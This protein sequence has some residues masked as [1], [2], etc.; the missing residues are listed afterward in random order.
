[1]SL[2]HL[3]IIFASIL[4]S[5]IVVFQVLLAFGLPLGNLAWGGENRILPVKL[6]IA[7]LISS[8]LLAFGIVVLLEKGEFISIINSNIVITI[9]L[10]VFVF[11]FGLSTLGNLTSKSD[12]EK[13]IMTPIAIIL[14]L[15]CLALSIL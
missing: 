15:V 2:I 3:A 10:W 6:R 12:L 13:K 7:S 11:I 1:M 9:T 8:F 4:L 14:F 5:G